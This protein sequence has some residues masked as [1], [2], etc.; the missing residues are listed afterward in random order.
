MIFEIV[1]PRYNTSVYK[2][3][4]SLYMKPL[5]CADAWDAYSMLNA[6][7]PYNH[8]THEGTMWQFWLC[9]FDGYENCIE[10]SNTKE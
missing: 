3:N 2:N 9:N 4:V 5:Y 10:F 7:F 1:E 8:N 6:A